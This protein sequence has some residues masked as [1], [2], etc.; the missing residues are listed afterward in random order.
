MKDID[1]VV[2]LKMAYGFTLLLILAVLAALFGLGKVESATSYGL[3]PII[4]ALATLLGSFGNWAFGHVVPKE[5]NE[6]QT[7]AKP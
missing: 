1:R 7:N 4:T 6:D 3:M 5:Q 2:L